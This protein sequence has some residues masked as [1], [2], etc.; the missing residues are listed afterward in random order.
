[1]LD[2]PT[3][4]M[5]IESLEVLEGELE[6]LRAPWRSSPTTAT[7]WNG[8]PDRIVEVRDGD[9]RTYPGGYTVWQECSLA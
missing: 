5:D 1:V 7:S 6:G 2:E 8:S 4:H 3:N 9:I